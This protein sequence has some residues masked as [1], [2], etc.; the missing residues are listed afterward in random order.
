V[1]PAE[2]D[3]AGGERVA[4]MVTG[5]ILGRRGQQRVDTIHHPS[6][7][8]TTGRDKTRRAGKAR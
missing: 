8:M 7:L 2:S 5:F 1:T 4:E 6:R 3:A